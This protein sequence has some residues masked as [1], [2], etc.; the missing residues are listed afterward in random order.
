MYTWERQ[1]VSAA[2]TTET[3]RPPLRRS[4]RFATLVPIAGLIDI[5]DGGEL[6]KHGPRPGW[7]GDAVTHLETAV[8]DQSPQHGVRDI[9]VTDDHR[10]AFLAISSSPSWK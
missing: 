4:R 1:V 3:V 5:G 6:R 2:W 8:P 7:D 10:Y 9:R